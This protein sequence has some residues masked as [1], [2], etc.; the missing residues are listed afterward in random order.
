[1]GT[2]KG[3]EVEKVNRKK[4]KTLGGSTTQMDIIFR[5]IIAGIIATLVYTALN[6]ALFAFGILPSTVVHYA[7]VLLMPPPGTGINALS[8]TMGAIGVF[9]AGSLLSVIL[10]IILRRTGRDF[11]WLKGIGVG[12]ILWPTHVALIPSAIIPRVFATLPP[13]MVPAILLL[14]IIWGLV[15]AL[16]LLALPE[17]QVRS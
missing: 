16:V 10:A 13:L 1:M 6:W 5:G 15:A 2:T 12:A 7:A 9:V 4:G 3:E 17:Q 8:I 11:A 14:S